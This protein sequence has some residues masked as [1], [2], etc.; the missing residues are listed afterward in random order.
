M[1]ISQ[2]EADHLLSMYKYYLENDNV[3][4]PVQGES[5]QI[6]LYSSDKKENFILDIS[7][8]MINLSKVKYQNR[9]TNILILARLDLYGNHKNPD[10]EEI[11][12]PH[13]HIYKEGY[14][15]KWAYPI[16]PNI[17][18]N[19]SDLRQTLIDF[20]RYCNIIKPPDFNFG[21]FP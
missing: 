3:N 14:H 15:D 10:G 17:F 6:P 21:L 16:D 13:I 1:N 19:Y 7:R 20:M 8:S 5:I 11:A 2:E 12:Y 9:A 4:F 18:T